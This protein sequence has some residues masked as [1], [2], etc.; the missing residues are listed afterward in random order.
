MN[1]KLRLEILRRFDRQGDF[2]LAVGEH[3]SKVSQVL[4]GRRQLSEEQAQ[5]WLQVLG[6]DPAV[7]QTVTK[8]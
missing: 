6:C 5:K 7:L 8:A 4:R 3:E 2:A 1:K